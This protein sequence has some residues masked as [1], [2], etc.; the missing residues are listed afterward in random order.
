[1]GYDMVLP[2]F[3]QKNMYFLLQI[4]FV[5]QRHPTSGNFDKCRSKFYFD[6]VRCDIT[7]TEI[8]FSFGKISEN[9]FTKDLH[10]SW[11][12]FGITLSTDFFKIVKSYLLFLMG[13]GSDLGNFDMLFVIASGKS[14]EN[15]SVVFL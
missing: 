15:P 9:F 1:M 8:P 4:L 13:A 2:T 3:F 7:L 11:K 12:R 10:W 5:M 6:S 14:A